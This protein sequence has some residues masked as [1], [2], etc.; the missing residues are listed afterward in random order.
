M[1][2]IT[3]FL[4]VLAIALAS[5]QKNG[6]TVEGTFSDNTFDGKV[7]FLQKI[8]SLAAEKPTIID[9]ATVKG[10]KFTFKGVAEDKPIMGFLSVGRLEQAE[11]NSPVATFI[12]EEGTINVTF[13]DVA[14]AVGGTQRNDDFNK[15]LVIMNQLADLYKAVSDAGGVEGMPLDSA[16]QD[17]PTRVM[18]LQEDMK[19]AS[20]EFMKGNMDNKAGEFLFYNSASSLSREEL[21]E[22]I[23]LGD[24]TFRNTPNIKMLE[25]ELNRVIP[26]VGQQYSDVKLVDKDGNSVDL[27][28]YVGESKCLLVDFWAS[29]C[30]PCIQ[31]M[32]NLIK[33]YNTYKS[34]GLQIVGISVDDDKAAWLDAVNKHKMTWIQLADASRM[35]SETYGVNTIPHTILIDQNGTIVAKDLR[36]KELDDKIAEMLK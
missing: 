4:V 2:K 17:V 16:G 33:A 8:D 15:T 25:A 7:V 3:F 28:V 26:A 1:K 6:Y 18:K 30:G 20:L 22:L 24:S 9:S 21:S 35:A 29:W 11:Q 12:L 27:S 32:P 13:K 34:K 5:C 36:G 14:V 23:A 19:K 31:E 10:N